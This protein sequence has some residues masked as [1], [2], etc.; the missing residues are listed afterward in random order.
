MLESRS[1]SVTLVGLLLCLT[2][3]SGSLLAEESTVYNDLGE[4]LARRYTCLAHGL[5]MTDEYPKIAYPQDWAQWGY[6]GELV[7]DTVLTVESFVG[8][9]RGGP[10]VKLEDMYLVTAD[11]PERL[12]TYPFEEVLLG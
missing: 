3:A 6:D 2:A 1:V 10:G 8:S 11:G 5:G 9:D 4:F 12:S 7:A